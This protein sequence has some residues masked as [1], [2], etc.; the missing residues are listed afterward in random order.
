MRR[1]GAITNGNGSERRSAR[2]RGAER[3]GWRSHAFGDGTCSITLTTALDARTA[4]RLRDAMR[5]LCERGCERLIVDVTAA[6]QTDPQ[7][8][9]LLASVFRAYMPSCEVVVIVPRESS[10]DRLLPARVAV[11]WSMVD[12]RRLLAIQPGF[13]RAAPASTI[14]PRDRHALAVRQAL[15]WAEQ[16][17]GTG[18]YESALRGLATIELVE[19]ALP[20]RW[21]ARREAWLVASRN[22][23]AAARPR[24]DGAHQIARRSSRS[25][26]GE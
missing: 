4:D 18:D 24:R 26:Q 22:Q 6:P 23:T 25:S 15:R 21:Q 1:A 10:L 19:G 16:T 17:A 14:D 5:E 8:P 7:G 13:E 12:A 11:A 2:G 3:A 20:E 9:G